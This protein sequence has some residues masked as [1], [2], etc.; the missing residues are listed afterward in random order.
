[1]WQ[2]RCRTRNFHLPKAVGLPDL[3]NRQGHCL[4]LRRQWEH[5]ARAPFYQVKPAASRPC[6]DVLNC[7]ATHTK[8]SGF[9][10]MTAEARG[11]GRVLNCSHDRSHDRSHFVTQ[12]VQRLSTSRPRNRAGW[13]ISRRQEVLAL[14]QELEQQ[15]QQQQQQQPA[16]CSR[17]SSRQPAGSSGRQQAGQLLAQDSNAD[18]LW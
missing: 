8:A 1:M 12:S 3:T 18:M 13:R 7:S 9:G 2:R 6:S 10:R 15:Q 14:A 11:R 17:S 4:S 5:Q 16:C